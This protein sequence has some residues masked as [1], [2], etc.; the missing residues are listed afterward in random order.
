MFKN[1]LISQLRVN[2]LAIW[3]TLM[4]VVQSSSCVFETHGLQHNR[5]PC[6]SLSSGVCSNL[7]SLSQRCHTTISCYVTP[8]SSC[9]LSFPAS[10]SFPMSQFFISGGQSS[11]ASAS[12]SILPMN[13]QGWFPLAL[14]GLI[15][16]L[17]KGLSSIF[18]RTTVEKH[19]FFGAL[20]FLWSNSHSHA[21]KLITRTLPNLSRILV[22]NIHKEH[23]EEEIKVLKD[24]V[25]LLFIWV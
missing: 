15:F 22:Y 5:L 6:P 2:L 23:T 16:L 25:H 24:K 4:V 11:G 17:S 18:S 13:I 14:F 12:A 10:E 1:I 3:A 20:P 8:F 9:P 21:C 19:Q 7:C